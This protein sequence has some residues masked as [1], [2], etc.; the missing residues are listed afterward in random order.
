MR[1]LHLITAVWGEKH[2]GWWKAVS[3]KSL[4]WPKNKEAIKGATWSI[5]TEEHSVPEIRDAC[6]ALGF[7]DSQLMFSHFGDLLEKNPHA[8]G[9]LLKEWFVQEG[10]LCL[11]YNRQCLIVP[12]DT[13]FGDGSIQSMRAI[14]EH[15]D[16]VVFAVHMRLNTSAIAE[17]TEKPLS[18]AELVTLAM[19]HKH[20]T[21]EES[22]VGLAKANSYVGGVSWRYIGENLWSVTHRLPTPYLINFTPEDL[23]YFK[24]QI[25]FGILDHSWPGELLI[26]SQ[27]QRLIG[28]S[29]GAF[30]VEI[31]EP[32]QNIPPLD[33][34]KLEEPDIFWRDLIHNRVNRMS[35]VILRGE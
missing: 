31:T 29:D 32:D 34:V 12:P 11:T 24:N 25:H 33:Y 3:L 1:K 6:N 15:R 10:G 23:V 2:I 8:G 14:G 35:S 30:M 20:K 4:A 21:W 19:K 13:A 5:L 9:A 17:I 26:K 7:E 22:E 27:R 16:T 18:N 28:S